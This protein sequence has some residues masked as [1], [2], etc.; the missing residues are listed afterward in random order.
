MCVGDL[1]LKSHHT[2]LQAV[3]LTEATLGKPSHE[4]PLQR[5]AVVV[6]ILVTQVPVDP[7]LI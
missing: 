6:V 5:L 1:T 7:V 3:V 2:E 4:C